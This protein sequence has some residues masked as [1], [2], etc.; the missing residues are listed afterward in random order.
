[1]VEMSTTSFKLLLTK[2]LTVHKETKYIE[3]FKTYYDNCDRWDL[4]FRS[5][6]PMNTNMHAE[7]FHRV[8]KIV[9]LKQKVNRHFRQT[10][11]I[12]FKKCKN[13]KGKNTNRIWDINKR[14]IRAK[15]LQPSAIIE[16]EINCNTGLNLMSYKH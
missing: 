6:S 4:C 2:F 9:Y 14:H 1:M 11:F 8:L 3:Y 13:E 12:F 5:G 16:R 10:F 7:S 15:S